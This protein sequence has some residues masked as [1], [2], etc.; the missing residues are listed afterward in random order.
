VFFFLKKELASHIATAIME[1]SLRSYADIHC[2]S[3]VWMQSNLTAVQLRHQEDLVAEFFYHYRS[4]I[5]LA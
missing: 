1:I 2:D 4:L 3:P 5:A